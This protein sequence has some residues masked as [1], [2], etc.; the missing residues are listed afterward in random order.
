[1][2]ENVNAT[3][4]HASTDF[5]CRGAGHHHFNS[6]FAIRNTT[7]TYNRQLN[8]FTN[9]INTPYRD[10]ASGVGDLRDHLRP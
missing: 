10:W 1:M 6:I 9:I 7:T 5:Y 8:S 2:L 3:I 4:I